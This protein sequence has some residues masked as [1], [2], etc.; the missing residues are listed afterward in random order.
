MVS[1]T[2][3]AAKGRVVV[4]LALKPGQFPARGLQTGKRVSLYAVG[5]GTGGGPRAGTLLSADAIVVGMAQGSVDGN[6]LRGDQTSVDVAVPPAEAPQVTQAASA[7]SIAV[8]LIPEGTRLPSGG[9]PA[10][11]PPEDSTPPG[12]AQTP[13]PGTSGA[14]PPGGEQGGQGT[15]P[16]TGGPPAGTGGN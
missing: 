6:R 12:G 11:P 4:G 10:P 13:E 2:N 5:G 1:R 14:P 3:D 8:A 16:G 9:R 15:P 7:A